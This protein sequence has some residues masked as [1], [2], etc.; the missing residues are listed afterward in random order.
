ML[1]Y[2]S[3]VFFQ[4]DADGSIVQIEVFIAEEIF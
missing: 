4:G 1:G 3:L 2:R